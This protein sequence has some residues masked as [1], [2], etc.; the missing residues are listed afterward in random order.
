M[1]DPN[2]RAVQ[3]IILAGPAA[4]ER[5]VFGFASALAAAASGVEVRVVLSM[6]GAYWAAET[7]GQAVSIMDFPP[8]AELIEQL[9]ELKT[10]IEACSTCIDNFCPSPYD[11]R[12]LRLLRKGIDRVGLGLVAMR[13]AS[14]STIVC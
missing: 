8:I 5:A 7:T 11:G 10:P 14:A 2:E 3:I 4:P 13:M 9:L 12:G 6:H 1:R